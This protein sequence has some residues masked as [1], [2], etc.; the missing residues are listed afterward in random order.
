M[1]EISVA[2]RDLLEANM[3]LRLDLKRLGNLEKSMADIGEA[4]QPITSGRL[5]YTDSLSSPWS[6]QHLSQAVSEIGLHGRQ[7]TFEHEFLRSLHFPA[8]ESRHQSIP[9]AHANTYSWIFPRYLAV[10]GASAGHEL[11]PQFINQEPQLSGQEISEDSRCKA[12]ASARFGE[13]LQYHNGIFWVEGKAG[14]GKSTL[15]KFISGHDMTS[16]L[17]LSWAKA[18]WT[19]LRRIDDEEELLYADDATIEM[20]YTKRR[21]PLDA[22]ELER[23]RNSRQTKERLKF[24]AD[25]LQQYMQQERDDTSS[26]A[27]LVVAKCFFWNAGSRLQKSLEGLLRCWL[28]DILQQCPEIVTHARVSS[29]D[30]LIRVRESKWTLESLM[31]LLEECITVRI[32]ASFC[33]FVDGLDE[34]HDEGRNTFRQLL[35]TLNHVASFPNVKI[36]A[37]SR[38]WTIFLDAFGV[39]PERTFKLENLTR[40]DIREYV[41][42]N[43]KNHDQYV[44]LSN[45][46]DSYSSLIEEVSIRARGVFLWVFLVVKDLLDGLTYNDSVQTMMQRLD[47]FPQGLEEFFQHIMDSVPSVYRNAASR[48]FSATLAANEPLLLMHH[49]FMDRIESDPNFCISRPQIPMGHSEV[50]FLCQQMKRQIEGRTKGL[51]EVVSG[52][53]TSAPYFTAQVDFLHRTVKEFLQGSDSIE[54]RSG[55]GISPHSRPWVLLCRGVVALL[56]YAPFLTSASGGNN[57]PDPTLPHGRREEEV[58]WFHTLVRQFILFADRALEDPGNRDTV[59]ALNRAVTGVCDLLRDSLGWPEA[60]NA[61]PEAAC[62]EGALLLLKESNLFRCGIPA[63]EFESRT[64]SCLRVALC[65]TGDN[66][67]IF[68]DTIGYLL[69]L[70]ADVNKTWGSGIDSPFTYFISRL[71]SRDL[72]SEGVGVLPT[73]KLLISHGANLSVG[74]GDSVTAEDIIRQHFTSD[75]VTLLMEGHTVGSCRKHRDTGDTKRSVADSEDGQMATHGQIRRRSRLLFYK[76]GKLIK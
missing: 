55:L 59:L 10:D 11:L 61:L 76:I 65:P 2:I 71:K 57:G 4:L 38:P 36:C 35:H 70:G 23:L 22:K 14:S 27:K 42:D 52:P 72:D 48:T 7:L 17:L 63:A 6:L 15:M 8:I 69:D 12:L 5:R 58:R 1:S 9:A 18:R 28:F 29:D 37:S 3:L 53:R 24:E 64:Q 34:F 26:G 50:A 68:P 13:W 19:T 54:D 46:D 49:S 33:L 67:K 21:G 60:D 74:I 43:F 20:A 41:K 51:L 32:S 25:L 31:L 16:K 47:Q 40:D 30:L 56:R 66:G 39:I 62:R 73:L 75:Q 45:F 44:R